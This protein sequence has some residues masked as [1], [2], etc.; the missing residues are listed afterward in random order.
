MNNFR[1]DDMLRAYLKKESSRL[2]ISI[3]NTYNTFFSRNLLS[4]LSKTDHEGNLI[5]T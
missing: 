5:V 3:Q 2:D 1:N 4:R